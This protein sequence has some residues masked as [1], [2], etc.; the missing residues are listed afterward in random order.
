M[1]L[2]IYLVSDVGGRAHEEGP[3]EGSLAH[4][5]DVHAALNH[6]RHVSPGHTQPH[7]TQSNAA[8]TPAMPHP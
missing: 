5:R 4:R 6:P 3:G 1:G 8:C 7:M 2:E